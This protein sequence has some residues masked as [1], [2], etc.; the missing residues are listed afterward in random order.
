MSLNINAAKSGSENVLDLINYTNN[1]TITNDQV[2][3]SELAFVDVGD[4][5][6]F[7]RNTS[8]RVKAVDNH[9]LINGP[10]AENG[11]VVKYK[12]VGLN[13]G[14]VSFTNVFAIDATTTWDGLRSVIAS[15]N[16]II[17]AD[18]NIFEQLD[19]DALGTD[20]IIDTFPPAGGGEGN[21]QAFNLLPIGPTDLTGT[22]PSVSYGYDNTIV[23][24]TGNWLATDTDI[25]TVIT[26]TDLDG[27]VPAA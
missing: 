12:R 16:G 17:Y 19:V 14:V 3:F 2:G 1:S 23:S 20:L 24:V 22:Q 21:T 6:A 27:F 13:T 25:G 4:I 10:T 7:G 9:G 18:F 8:L 15:T 11:V 26:V 5:D